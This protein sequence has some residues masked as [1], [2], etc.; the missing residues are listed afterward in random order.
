MSD[1]N[2]DSNDQN[3]NFSHRSNLVGGADYQHLSLAQR[4]NILHK[5]GMVTALTLPKISAR[6]E[7]VSVA[8]GSHAKVQQGWIVVDSQGRPVAALQPLELSRYLVHALDPV[9]YR[10]VGVEVEAINGKLGLYDRVSGTYQFIGKVPTG[11]IGRSISADVLSGNVDKN[12]WQETTVPGLGVVTWAVADRVNART[13][14]FA[15][16]WKGYYRSPH[17][18]L[19]CFIKIVSGGNA[20][21]AIARSD[22]YLK[23]AAKRNPVVAEFAPPSG[24]IWPKGAQLLEG[25]GVAEG[26][27]LIV[28]RLVTGP[29][30]QDLAHGFAKHGDASIDFSHPRQ[31]ASC[32]VLAARALANLN[33]NAP[34][35][36]RLAAP[37]AT[38]PD[39]L[40][41]SGFTRNAYGE[42]VPIALVC[43][44]RDHYQLEGAPSANMHGTFLFADFRG[45]SAMCS[46]RD[47]SRVDKVHAFQ[48]GRMLLGVSLGSS[49]PE[50]A[51]VL[52]Q[53]THRDVEAAWLAAM[54]D[55][56]RVYEEGLKIFDARYGTTPGTAG[57]DLGKLIRD[58]CQ[59]EEDDRP[60]LKEIEERASAIS[61]LKR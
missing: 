28:E 14:A 18:D 30:L 9:G 27:A 26:S 49:L 45:L 61:L 22:R 12:A 58:C 52:E 32:G 47:F 19:E 55:S 36:H 5:T 25:D 29:T 57:G 46:G 40:M 41:C 56:T 1:A 3:L 48:V 34:E 44:D 10:G 60:S 31:F 23:V 35:G 11:L 38:K 16:G 4:L 24:A 17:R 7:E 42:P 13:G 53:D 20:V 51:H 2:S 6:A 50:T 15:K 33:H 54:K 39:N 21:Q 37:D 59:F 8:D 43:P